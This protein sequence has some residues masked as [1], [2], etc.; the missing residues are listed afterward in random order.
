MNA[1]SLV[2][3]YIEEHYHDEINEKTVEYVTGCTFEEFA[4][5]FK[6]KTGVTFST[7]LVRRQ[8]TRINDELCNITCEKDLNCSPFQSWEE[9]ST[10][11]KSEFKIPI[12]TATKNE[13]FILQ[14]KIGS[15]EW[16]MC[17]LVIR[18]LLNRFECPSKALRYLLSLQP[19]YFEVDSEVIQPSRSNLISSIVKKVHGELSLSEFR[20]I[21]TIL[22]N[23]YML[24]SDYYSKHSIDV[25]KR[26]ILVFRGLINKLVWEYGAGFDYEVNELK[27]LW[28][29]SHDKELI[30]HKWHSNLSQSVMEAIKQQDL[31]N[32][33]FANI[34]ELFGWVD[35]YFSKQ[36]KRINNQNFNKFT[37]Y[38]L[39][40]EGCKNLEEEDL[41]TMINTLLVQGLLFLQLR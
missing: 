30:S 22:E 13:H 2:L 41:T 7:Y 39:I 31:G 4:K 26:Y 6:E 37:R 28:S 29:V 11:F 35:V 24:E 3:D 32:I 15:K 8:L 21:V 18:D 12:D 14:E 25:S 19:Y 20:K 34:D 9:L 27:T 40:E 1:I 23:Y 36:K 16:N 17:D 33:S 5:K 10:L 38:K